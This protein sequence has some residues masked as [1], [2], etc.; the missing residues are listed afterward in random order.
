MFLAFQYIATTLLRPTRNW[1][2]VIFLETRGFLWKV[3]DIMIFWGAQR[4]LHAE[5]APQ[6]TQPSK[7]PWIHP[8]RS[9][10]LPRIPNR[11]PDNHLN[12]YQENHPDH[13]QDKHQ[14]SHLDICGEN[15]LYKYYLR[16]KKCCSTYGSFTHKWFNQSLKNWWQN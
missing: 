5:Q 2:E 3:D 11:H 15:H 12:N 10:Q 1:L 13:R 9:R 7:Q 14:K 4:N 8:S 16:K 6:P